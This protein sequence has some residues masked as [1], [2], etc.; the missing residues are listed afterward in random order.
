MSIKDTAQSINSLNET[1]A[2]NNALT[3]YLGVIPGNFAAVMIFVLG[4]LLIYEFAG[5][6]VAISMAGIVAVLQ[7]MQIFITNKK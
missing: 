4:I 1:T 2:N 3:D 5:A 6:K 7:L